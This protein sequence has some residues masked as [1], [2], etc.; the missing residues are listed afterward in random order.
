VNNLAD[1]PNCKSSDGKAIQ[2]L[3]LP[4]ILGAGAMYLALMDNI[5]LYGIGQLLLSFFF[6]QTFILL[7]ECGHLNFFKTRKLNYA[8]GHLF[9]L[10]TMI[11]FF[12]W[13]HMHN[14]HHRWTGWRDKDPTTEKTVEPSEK[15]VMRVVAN[16]SWLLFIPV[17]YVFYKLSNY[18][19]L[20]KIKRF[21][22]PDKYRKSVVHVLIYLAIYVAL[23][24]FFGQFILIYLLPAFILS[25]IWKELIILTQH[26][27]VEIPVSEGKEVSPI[28]FKEQIPYTRS[29]YVNSWFAHYVLVNFNLHEAH[30][31]NPGMPAY[32]LGKVKLETP[33]EPSYLSWFLKAKS[34]KGEDYVFRTS[35][36]TGEKF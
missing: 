26:S 15:P 27:H 1:I 6:V 34:M 29:F 17:F 8:F 20:S 7:H 9:G 33:E 35:K 28:A 14:M 32:F 11:P 31:A 25:W 13:K 36:H 18:W 3:I 30:H 22:N 23:G 12:T 24:I 5:Y 21:A 19:N 16:I 4:F 10:L 2:A